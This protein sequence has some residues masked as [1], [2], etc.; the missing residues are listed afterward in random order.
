MG[1]SEVFEI[2][3]KQ[4]LCCRKVS[5]RQPEMSFWRHVGAEC[6]SHEDIFSLESCSSDD[7]VHIFVSFLL[8]TWCE[9]KPGD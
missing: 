7:Y 4:I 5:Q 9:I 2:D 1:K 3:G 8:N 6:V